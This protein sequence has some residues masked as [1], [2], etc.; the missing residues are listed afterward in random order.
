MYNANDLEQ[1]RPQTR[2]GKH[3][4]NTELIEYKIYGKTTKGCTR[5]KMFDHTLKK[6][7]SL[8]PTLQYIVYWDNWHRKF[9]TQETLQGWKVGLDDSYVPSDPGDLL[10]FSTQKFYSY[11]VFEKIL[12]IDEGRYIVCKNHEHHD[13]QGVYIKFKEFS[14][15]SLQMVLL[16]P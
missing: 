10:L 2:S 11:S 5:A 12:K 13:E 14:A 9:K 7:P 4:I 6:D 16:M 1:L 3:G 8:F 15:E